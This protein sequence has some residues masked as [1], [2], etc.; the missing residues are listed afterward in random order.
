[1]VERVN[2]TIKNGTIKKQNYENIEQLNIALMNF[3][4]FYNLNRRHG[5]LRKELNVK[6]PFDAIEKWYEIKPNI[7][8]QNPLQF[9]NKIILLQSNNASLQQQPCET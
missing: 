7:F 3:L 6:T 9:K 4:V 5:G 2:G 8:N 1:M